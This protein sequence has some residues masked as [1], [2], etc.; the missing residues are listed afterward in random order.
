MVGV[1]ITVV[2]IFFAFIIFVHTKP[3]VRHYEST[4]LA[5]LVIGLVIKIGLEIINQNDGSM[6]TAIV[7][8]LTFV[9]FSVSTYKVF[10]ISIIFLIIYLFRVLVKY[11]QELDSVSMA[12]ISMNY[13]ALL[14]GITLISAFVGYALEK[15]RR[16]N[17][18]LR[19]KLEYQFQKGQ[20]ILGNLLPK[21]VK[22]R[23]KQ[24]VRYIAE[25]QGVVTLL[26][27]DIYDF[28]RI[29]VTHT[30]NELIDLLDKFFAIL[31]G[32]CEKHGV[33]KIE[34]VNKSYLVCGGLKDSEENLPPNLL[35]KNH[36]VRILELALNILKKLEPVYLK[37]GD[38]FEVKIGINSGPIIAGVVGDHKPQFSLIGDTINTASRMCS[39]IKEP[40]HVQ[41]SMNTYEFVKDQHMI[42]TPNQIEA[43]GKGMLD[44]FLVSSQT[45]KKKN[46]RVTT[47][48]D[49]APALYQQQP[50]PP[51]K[52]LNASSL[53]LIPSEA[54]N[55]DFRIASTVF[56]IDQI[57]YEN[58]DNDED[59]LGLAGPVQ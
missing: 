33:T 27:C 45:R 23:V 13:M 37:N 38:K 39:T 32:L 9:L 6:T 24:G 18:I 1:R 12:I 31:D 51:D 58:M 17:Y 56:D 16:T 8:I 57:Q 4:V 21:F 2:I 11:G 46:R 40:G 42:F 34:T 47:F 7:P 49:I 3:F 54:D 44:T 22:D 52:I 36:A 55:S 19:K 53:P 29:C 43:K 10:T 26:F 15:S 41:I 59:Y 50:Q 20:D 5:V 30:P 48:D 14:V 28:D 35:A 25:D